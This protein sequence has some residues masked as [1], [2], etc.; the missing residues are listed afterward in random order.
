MN[1]SDRMYVFLNCDPNFRLAISN[2]DLAIDC[3]EDVLVEEGFCDVEVDEDALYDRLLQEPEVKELLRETFLSLDVERP[4]DVETEPGYAY[5]SAGVI[6]RIV[7]EYLRKLTGCS[8]VDAYLADLDKDG[9]DLRFERSILSHASEPIHIQ[10]PDCRDPSYRHVIQMKDGEE[11]VFFDT[12]F[13]ERKIFPPILADAG[14]HVGLTH[15][16]TLLYWDEDGTPVRQLKESEILALLF[17]ALYLGNT[18]N[19]PTPGETSDD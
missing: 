9:L 2:R 8:G 6:Q 13:F 5:L 18:N 12:H 15:E 19:T 1:A 3:I 10:S 14:P 4:N 17:T 16:D 11:Y 7:M